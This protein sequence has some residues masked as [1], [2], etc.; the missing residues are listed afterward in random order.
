MLNLPCQ[1]QP[2]VECP[3]REQTPLAPLGEQLTKHLLDQRSF[4]CHMRAERQC[5]GHM[6]LCADTNEFV[7]TAK[8]L[9][10]QLA[11]RNQPG[12]FATKED[13]LHDHQR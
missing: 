7:A 2:C 1:K 5:A 12:V 9:G 13:C 3:F 11:L 6:L 8:L 4:L 10:I